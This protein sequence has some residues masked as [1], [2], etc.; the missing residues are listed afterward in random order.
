MGIKDR[1]QHAWNAFANKDPTYGSYG[2]YR[3]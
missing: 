1:L 3:G 2:G